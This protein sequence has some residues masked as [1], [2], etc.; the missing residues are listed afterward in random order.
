VEY[1]ADARVRRECPGAA[2]VAVGQV[3]GEVEFGRVN[4]WPEGTWQLGS[5]FLLYVWVAIFLSLFNAQCVAIAYESVRDWLT[6]AKPLLATYATPDTP[7]F[8][9]GT[10]RD[11][12]HEKRRP[13]QRCEIHA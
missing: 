3:T 10:V 8:T 13:A 12:R 7:H 4:L 6:T 5:Q 9:N 1:C 11:M 2:K